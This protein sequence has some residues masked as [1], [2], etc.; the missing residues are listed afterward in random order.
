MQA[1]SR[2]V[3][4]L[5]VHLRWCRRKLAG[6]SFIRLSR[7]QHERP[8]VPGDL[9][10]PLD[11]PQAPWTLTSN[12]LHT[13]R[14]DG[15]RKALGTFAGLSDPPEQCQSP[16]TEKAARSCFPVICA[17]PVGPVSP[18][19][20][21]AMIGNQHRQVPTIFCGLEPTLKQL[22][23]HQRSAKIWTLRKIG[24]CFTGKPWQPT[25]TATI[26][27]ASSGGMQ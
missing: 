10:V 16:S 24:L 12:A 2:A 7:N 26:G 19:R 17:S 6:L 14:A 23:A 5:F 9:P 21:A 15:P 8:R 4:H 3:A 18:R 20:S 25:E 13:H 27:L 11:G 1:F 22:A